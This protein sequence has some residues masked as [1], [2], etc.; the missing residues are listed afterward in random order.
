MRNTI[1]S[2]EAQLSLSIGGREVCNETVG[3]TLLDE[4]PAEEI[5]VAEYCD[6]PS[7][8]PSIERY[9]TILF[10]VAIYLCCFLLFFVPNF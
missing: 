4:A 7:K 9:Q 10:E 6:R 2:I 3:E 1:G 5:R 8:T